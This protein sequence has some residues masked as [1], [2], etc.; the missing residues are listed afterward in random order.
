MARRNDWQIETE[1][2]CPHCKGIFKDMSKFC[3]DCGKQL[4]FEEVKYKT[5]GEVFT[6]IDSERDS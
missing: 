1:W 2:R 3:P 5:L 6:E 4:I